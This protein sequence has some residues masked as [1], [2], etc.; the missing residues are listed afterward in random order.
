MSAERAADRDRPLVSVITR[1]RDRPQLLREA[2]AS[3]AEQTWPDRELVVVNDGGADVDPVLAPFRERLAIVSLSPG[4]VGRCRAG[5]LG[6][7][8]AGGRYLAYL[9]DDDL[10]LPGHLETLVNALEASPL[11]FAYGDPYRADMEPGGGDGSWR[12]V[13]RSVPYSQEFSR[14]ALFRS[15]YIHLAGVMHHRE[16]YER[17]GGFDEE[18]EVLEDLD[19]FLRYAQEYDF[20]HVPRSTSVFRIRSDGSNAVTALPGEFV[21]T[22]ARLFSRY[23]HVALSQLAGMVEHG[24]EL[25]GDLGRRVGDLEQELRRIKGQPE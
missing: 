23:A 20:L 1:T 14:L 7:E 9:D 8:A 22:R 13:R 10:Y 4:R 19:L 3:V 17:L 15:S 18:L 24:Q 6:L 11:K 25:L 16:C 2:V 12:E 21:H 5:N